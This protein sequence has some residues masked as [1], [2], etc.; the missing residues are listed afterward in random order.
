MQS[1]KLAISD[2]ELRSPEFLDSVDEARWKDAAR[3]MRRCRHYDG[4]ED[5]PQKVPGWSGFNAAVSSTTPAPSVVG[6]CSVIEASSTELLTVYTLLQ[7]SMEM[8]RMLGLDEIII[9]MPKRKRVFGNNKEFSNVILRMGAFHTRM[10]FLAVI[11]KRLGNTGLSD[12][13]IEAGIVAAGS[14][15]A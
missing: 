10:T 11:G 12:I 5:A 13:F 3:F 14:V 8:G 9:A 6:Y 4:N 7:K 2:E 15:S 1:W